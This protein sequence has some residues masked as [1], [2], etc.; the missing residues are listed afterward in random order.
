MGIL[1]DMFAALKGAGSEV[2]EAIIDANAV[3]ILEQE[4]REAEKAI[5]NA[6]QSLTKLKGSEIRMKREINSLNTDISDYE[7][8]ALEALNQ[9]NEELAVKVADRIAEHETDRDEKSAEYEKLS[10]EVGKINTMIKNRN[11][12]IQKN[13][14]ELEKVKTIRELQKTTSS[15]SCNFA[16][17]GSSAH[18]V[19]KALERVK[20]KQAKWR[21][22]MEAGDWMV[23]EENT[24]DLSKELKEA[25]IGTSG[26]TGNS[27]L[28][29]LKE[30]QRPSA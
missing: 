2:G 6:R 28:D 16:A 21:D 30:K 1:K 24:D 12:V 3:R 23:E 4:I 11:K 17:T 8:K 26:I 27:V 14:R 20:A 7:A 25:G 18:R 10:A 9:G 15:I 19:S 13:K 5:N 22:N 29:R